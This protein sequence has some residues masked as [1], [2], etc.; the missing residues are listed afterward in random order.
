M[1]KVLAFIEI[2]NHLDST[3]SEY[4]QWRFQTG[5]DREAMDRANKIVTDE[6]EKAMDKIYK[7]EGQPRRVIGIHAR[8]KFKNSYQ[9]EC[10]FSLGH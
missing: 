2:D 6:D 7:I 10:S 8:R 9:Y 3:P 4:I 5:E 1:V